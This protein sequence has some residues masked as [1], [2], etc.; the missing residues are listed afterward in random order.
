[1]RKFAKTWAYR[2]PLVTVEFP[3]GHE[4]VD[5]DVIAAAQAAGVLKEESDN[6][7]GNDNGLATRGKTGRTV[8]LK[9]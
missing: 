5:A 4:T 2:T 1:M 3:A 6:G 8:N 9:G 7:D